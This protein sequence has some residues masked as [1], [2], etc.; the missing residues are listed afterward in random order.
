MKKVIV[1]SV[2]CLL[3]GAANAAWVVDLDVVRADVP[4][5]L[6]TTGTLIKATNLGVSEAV[7]VGGVDFDA[8]QSNISNFTGT[9]TKVYY[10]DGVAG[11]SDLE[12][13][14]NTQ[15]TRNDSVLATITLDVTAGY[16]YRVQVI[17]GNRWGWQSIYVEGP[18]GEVYH[19]SGNVGGEAVNIGTL[20]FTAETDTATLRVYSK[21]GEQAHIMAYSLYQYIVSPVITQPVYLSALGNN[22]NDGLTPATPWRDVDALDMREFGPG[23]QIWFNRGDTFPGACTLFGSGSAGEPIVIGAYGTGDK[24]HLTGDVN[25]EAVIYMPSYSEYIEFSDLHISNNFGAS[26][27]AIYHRK[28]IYI[29]PPAGSGAVHHFHFLNMDISNI[30]GAMADD[31]KTTDDDHR[32]YAIHA[33]IGNE[34]VNPSWFDD[35][36]VDGCTFVDIDGRGFSLN[37]SSQN[38][39]DFRLQGTGYSPSIGVVFQ[40]N[41][42]NNIWRNFAMISGAKDAVVQS[43]T[44]DGTSE[45][46]AFWNFATE[47]TL[48]QYN[49]FNN[50]SRGVGSDTFICHVGFNSSG[51]VHQY[52][53]GY[54]V[55]GGLIE[56]LCNSDV[57]SNFNEN[58]TM[59]Y[60][61]GVDVGYQEAKLNSAGILLSGRLDGTS[62]Y[63]NTVIQSN[64]ARA[65]HRALNFGN[66]GGTYPS[67]TLVT[68]NI[69]YVT[70]A[71][72]T[73]IGT[74]EMTMYGNVV[75]NNLYYG[76][77]TPP[78][79]AAGDVDPNPV[80]SD[81][82]FANPS[83]LSDPAS[84][85]PED[86]KVMFG[87]AAI[88]NGHVVADNGG[89]D[90]FGYT[91]SSTQAPTIGS[92]EFLLRG[93]LTGDERVDTRDT[94]EL[95]AG[96]QTDYDMNTLRD[97]A[98]N[99]LYTAS[100]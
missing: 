46:S 60:N 18:T 52:N 10:D 47:G 5:Y 31:G 27:P 65:L 35:V 36:L 96:W 37:D 23:A 77:I 51:T 72:S 61:I 64:P 21:D 85:T 99:W 87:S 7:T 38:Y 100:P 8:D 32:S 39:A 19:F 53:Y 25:G 12:K 43:N 90:Y 62:V 78:T 66:W 95:S 88:G 59:R 15:S 26:N 69:F 24:P 74:D 83:I 41:Y 49:V 93:D 17:S 45:G 14:L 80:T 76:N 34:D 48:V 4:S 56:V 79:N 75:T 1:L 98:N 44:M 73:F 29:V 67:N 20:E 40:N 92:Y 91:V 63:N 97:I 58:T 33:I 2:L 82:L 16:Y 22:A 81:P 28:A 89:R 71:A 94:A 30:A 3:V 70:A 54:N 13:L 50:L 86:L 6:Q 42:G 68:N 84:V 11:N 55:E 9:A 57:A